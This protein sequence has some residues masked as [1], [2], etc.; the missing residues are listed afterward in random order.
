MAASKEMIDAIQVAQGNILDQLGVT[1]SVFRKPGE[2]DAVFRRKVSLAAMTA[3]WEQIEV[4]LRDYLRKA[5]GAPPYHENCRCVITADEL[6]TLPVV[7]ALE[8]SLAEALDRPVP[9]DDPW[10][11]CAYEPPAAAGW[12]D[13]GRLDGYKVRGWYGSSRLPE[14]HAFGCLQAQADRLA[15]QGLRVGDTVRLKSLE[16]SGVV[17]EDP[18]QE[19][20]DFTL[21]VNSQGLGLAYAAFYDIDRTGMDPVPNRAPALLLDHPRCSPD[22]PRRVSLT[23]SEKF[24]VTERGDM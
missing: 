16:L 6:D 7:P 21:W 18:P 20:Y 1:Q 24:E 3:T 14:E 23:L 4:S 12:G 10:L 13:A 9:L 19:G 8:P 22:R 2:S 5:V 11:Q 15:Q 17:R